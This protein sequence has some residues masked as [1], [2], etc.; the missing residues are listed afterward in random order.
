[1]KIKVCDRTE[2]NRKRENKIK[3]FLL[4]AKIFSRNARGKRQ[5]PQAKNKRII[6]CR[7]KV[8]GN[9]YYG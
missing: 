7:K 3:Y 4:L 8:I 1:M 6:S 9:I 5:S 2:I